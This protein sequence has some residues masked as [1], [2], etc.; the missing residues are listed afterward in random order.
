M[1]EWERYIDFSPKTPVPQNQPIERW[2]KEN[3]T[4]VKKEERDIG[5]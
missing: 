3:I 1:Q 2:K 4:E 5:L